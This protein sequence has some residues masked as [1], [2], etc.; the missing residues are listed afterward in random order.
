MADRADP[1]L[2]ALAA[3]AERGDDVPRIRLIAGSA[4]AIGLP[5]SRERFI[6]VNREGLEE[7]WTK[8]LRP[9]PWP[10]KRQQ[11]EGPAPV[12]RAQSA[13]AAFGQPI[14]EETSFNLADV[15]W[16]PL[17]GGDGLSPPAIRIPLA[18]IDAWWVAGGRVERA[19]S[20]RGVWFGAIFP[21]PGQ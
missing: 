18:A 4:I 6:R 19:P 15:E 12:E 11:P 1:L 3:A 10:R 13:F 14:D 5:T 8:Y 16:W 20:G 17:G 2:L 7:E 21:I 9:G